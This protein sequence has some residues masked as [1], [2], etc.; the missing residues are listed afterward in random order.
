MVAL[1]SNEMA[2]FPDPKTHCIGWLIQD[3]EAKEV[4]KD[5]HKEAFESEYMDK[6][7]IMKSQH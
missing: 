2:W 7:I 6:N 1:S 5:K 3:E 4:K